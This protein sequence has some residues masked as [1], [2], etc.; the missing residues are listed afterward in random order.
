M[1]YEECDAMLRCYLADV[2]VRLFGAI[3]TQ[4]RGKKKKIDPSPGGGGSQ[5]VYIRMTSKSP[6]TLYSYDESI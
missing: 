5:V 4:K 2:R 3:G 6:V 1:S